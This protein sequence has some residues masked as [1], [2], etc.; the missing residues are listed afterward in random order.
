LQIKF[1]KKDFYGSLSSKG[2][3]IYYTDRK[4]R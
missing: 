2:G 1:G 4:E 3:N